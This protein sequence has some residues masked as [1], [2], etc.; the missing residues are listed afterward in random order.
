MERKPK[1]IVLGIGNTLMQDDGVGVKAIRSLQQSSLPE[2]IDMEI[3]D[4][5]TAPDLSV[6]V[7]RGVD[8]LIIIDAVQAHGIP[9]TIYRFTPA[10]L[11]GSEFVSAHDLSIRQSLAMMQLVGN[12][13]A[14][15]VIIGVE[16]EEIGWGTNLSSKIE[17]KLPDVVATVL[18]ETGV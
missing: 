16:P 14:E 8:K 6:F 1:V 9:G 5:G 15:T 13:P 4:V 2:G 10:L 17:Q 18:K 12:L 11:E 3:I 7:D